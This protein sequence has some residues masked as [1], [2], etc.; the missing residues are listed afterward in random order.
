MND[1]PYYVSRFVI[2]SR[3]DKLLMEKYHVDAM[4]HM[5]EQMV[6]RL[7]SEL[8]DQFM[9]KK[10]YPMDVE[11]SV[12]ISVMTPE[13]LKNGMN[14]PLRFYLISQGWRS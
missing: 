9:V 12:D 14:V 6:H 5:R 7:A 4:P 1:P 3:V 10:E 8:V 11:F 13:P 2:V